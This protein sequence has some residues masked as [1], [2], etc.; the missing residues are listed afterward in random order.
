M[1]SIKFT[2][3]ACLAVCLMHVSQ[4][5]AIA[6]GQCDVA[7]SQNSDARA[8]VEEIFV[9][10]I[11]RLDRA[12][13]LP[14]GFK[15]SLASVDLHVCA[16]SNFAAFVRHNHV[17]VDDKLVEALFNNSAALVIGGYIGRQFEDIDTLAMFDELIRHIVRQNSDPSHPPAGLHDMV[18]RVTGG[19]ATLSELMADRHFRR[20][21]ETLFLNALAFVIHHEQCHV[22]LGHQ[23]AIRK[24]T[25][26]P[27]E[28]R[29]AFE[30]A[31][32]IC[33]VDIINRHEF[34]VNGKP[35]T[36]YVGAFVF[37]A[38]SIAFEYLLEKYGG[39]DVRNERSHPFPH[40][41]VRDLLGRTKASLS[42]TPN[43]DP[44][45]EATLDGL[46]IY[47]D[48]LAKNIPNYDR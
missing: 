33:A 38:M 24:D 25:K 4:A 17:V 43:A 21:V 13:V 32:D 15:S 42:E 47:V 19:R 31:A 20:R 23:E 35:G 1:T 39:M 3:I 29:R 46:M 16:D 22:F 28:K 36:A 18:E 40:K 48:E 45:I 2:V 27:S 7:E 12:G 34:H 10:R 41:R 9:A 5:P 44:R 37:M 6:V 30:T 8:I 14:Q 11:A 26:L